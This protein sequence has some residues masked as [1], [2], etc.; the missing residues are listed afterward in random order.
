MQWAGCITVFAAIIG[1][2]VLKQFG[3]KKKAKAH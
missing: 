2:M 1:E 3:P